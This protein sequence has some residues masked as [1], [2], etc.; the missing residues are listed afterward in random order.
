MDKRI[1]YVEDTFT[2]KKDLPEFKVG[3]TITVHYKIIEGGKERT[4]PFQG[5]VIKQRGS[6][7][8]KTF[9]VRKV[10]QGV[11]VERIFP[12]HSP[13]LH[14]VKVDKKGKVKRSKLYY[15]RKAEGKKARIQQER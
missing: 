4:Q 5:V 10:S 9:T 3:D 14:S 2:P 1:K 6:G 11:G 13:K 7:N 12:M 15:L 8:G